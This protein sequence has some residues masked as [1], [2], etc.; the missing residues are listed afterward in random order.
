MILRKHP[1]NLLSHLVLLAF[2]YLSEFG[3]NPSTNV[4]YIFYIS[5]VSI[6]NKYFEYIDSIQV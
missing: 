3:F 2:I 6:K 4:A 1:N 5:G